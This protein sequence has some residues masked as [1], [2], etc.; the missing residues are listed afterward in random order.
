[1]GLDYDTHCKCAII[2]T[3]FYQRCSICFHRSDLR[4][5]LNHRKP[6]LW[7]C[8][9]HWCNEIGPS[10]MRWLNLFQ[11]MDK[12]DF[13]FNTADTFNNV[14]QKI[15]RVLYSLKNSGLILPGYIF[16]SISFG[17]INS[18]EFRSF[19]TNIHWFFLGTFNEAVSQTVI[20][21]KGSWSTGNPTS[22]IVVSTGWD[23]QYSN[24]EKTTRQVTQNMRTRKIP[25]AIR[26]TMFR[27]C[28]TYL[29]PGMVL[30]EKNETIS[31]FIGL[32]GERDFLLGPSIHKDNRI[33]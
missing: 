29:N 5:H 13:I 11:L 27:P 10:D 21:G 23:F 20:A 32:P 25:H 15:C 22:S 8:R 3:L 6:M 7:E 19:S 31:F 1:M 33:T 30:S 16:F 17:L 9:F 24:W 4:N 12:L 18:S 28:T 14:W 2:L 26:S